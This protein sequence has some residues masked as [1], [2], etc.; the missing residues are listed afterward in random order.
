MNAIIIQFDSTNKIVELSENEG[1][2]K[3]ERK[4]SEWSHSDEN[5]P[6]N[7]QLMEQYKMIDCQGHQYNQKILGAGANYK[8]QFLSDEETQVAVAE[9]NK[10]KALPKTGKT[11]VISI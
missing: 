5:L 10:M 11:G 9:I 8:I 2:L 6:T 3:I 1:T 4:L 7:A